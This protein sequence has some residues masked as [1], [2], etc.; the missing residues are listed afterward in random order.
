MVILVSCQSTVNYAVF[1]NQNLN[2][3]QFPGTELAI[4]MPYKKKCKGQKKVLLKKDV[5]VVTNVRR[6]CPQTPAP[7]PGTQPRT[8]LEKQK[9]FTRSSAIQN[10]CIFCNEDGTRYTRS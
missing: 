10:T 3:V 8:S 7:M 1:S 4:R 2:H 6:D 9:P 5:A